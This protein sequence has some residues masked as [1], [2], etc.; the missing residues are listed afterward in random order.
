VTRRA[1]I[2]LAL[3]GLLPVVILCA[4]LFRGGWAEPVLVLSCSAFPAVLYTIAPAADRGRRIGLFFPL[5]L[6]VLLLA[7]LW[8]VRFLSGAGRGADGLN[9]LLLALWFLPLILVSLFHAV[10]DRDDRLDEAIL[11][12]KR[13]FRRKDGEE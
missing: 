11:E 10:S 9:W 2:G 12:L 6:G 5:S 13:R 3:T 4:F 8:G 7:G 1:A